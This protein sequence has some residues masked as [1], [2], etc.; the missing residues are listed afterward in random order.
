MS[1]RLFT[2]VGGDKGLWN[3][4]R[5]SPV[6]GDDLARV[7]R[8][9]IFSGNPDQAPEG[10]QWILRGI[11]SNERYVTRQEQDALKAIQPSIGRP[12][13]T[14]A[15]L[16]PIKKSAAWWQLPQ[17]ERRAIF[18]TSSHHIEAGL[19]H[20]PA[21]ARR[22]HHGYDLGE[23]FD[24]LTW[25]EYPPDHAEAFEALVSAMR[26]TEEWDYV[27]REVDIRL[28]QENTV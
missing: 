20:L 1:N 8:V 2:F 18:E 22:L 26:E 19:K 3:V 12:E 28:R 24:F 13:A 7:E 27:E 10:C 9:E 4:I 17:D 23:P 21:V 5:M 14:C 15:A 16:I 6:I 25:F 11:T